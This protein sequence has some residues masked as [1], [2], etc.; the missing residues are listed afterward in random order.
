MST[1]F[2]GV[3]VTVSNPLVSV[4]IPAWNTAAYLPETLQSILLQS[5]ANYEVIMVDDASTDGTFDIMQA[6]VERDR[7]FI[8]IRQPSNQGVAAARNAALAIATGEYVALLDADDIWLPDALAIRIN[9][10]RDFPDAAVIATDF[11]WF[12]NNIIPNAVGRIM[13]GAK[14]QVFFADTY[15]TGQPKYIENA[16]DVVAELHFAWVGATL[17]R[18]EKISEIGNFTHGFDGQ[19]DT[20]LWLGLANSGTFVFIPVITAY[21]RQRAG[22]I[23]NLQRE[24]KEFYYLRVL[25]YVSAKPE[26]SKHRFVIKKLKMAC[27]EVCAIHFRRK[28]E[29]ACALKHT[30]GALRQDPLKF[31]HWYGL[32]AVVLMR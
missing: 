29:W 31:R 24:P 15:T 26:F 16:F 21:Y 14:A 13:L 32:A 20:I 19:E 30:F 1:L 11:A 8:A 22:S 28:K 27:H 5:Y 3:N 4:I 12:E 7:R 18:R 10:A 17:V 2:S 6:W 23:V 9:V 25:N